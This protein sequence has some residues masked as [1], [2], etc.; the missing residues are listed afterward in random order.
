MNWDQINKKL[1]ALRRSEGEEKE[2]KAVQA[3]ESASA[4]ALDGNALGLLEE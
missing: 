2:G 3:E 4:N 1:P